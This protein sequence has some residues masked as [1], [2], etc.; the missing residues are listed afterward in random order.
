MGRGDKRVVEA[1]NS[2]EM[3]RVE[4]KSPPA[5][6]MWREKRRELGEMKSKRARGN[7]EKQE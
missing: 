7:G 4:K 6:N 1:E 2:R 5:M 3:E